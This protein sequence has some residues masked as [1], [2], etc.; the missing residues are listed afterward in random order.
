VDAKLAR[1][2]AQDRIANALTVDV[3]D[4]FSVSAFDDIVSRD[5]WGSY[6]SRVCRNTERLLQCFEDAGVRGTFFVLGWVAERFPQ[7]VR[8]IAAAGHEIGS[9]SFSH[10][11][12]YD[13]TPQAFREDV[14]RASAAISAAAG[15]QVLGYRAPSFSITERSLW[16]LDILIEEGYV[17]D[18]SIF[19]V[20]HDRYGIPDA[21]REFHQITRGGRTLWECPS[22]TVRIGGVNLPTGGGGY[23]R[24]LPYA[25]TRWS[26][27]RIN[28]V[29]RRPAVFYLHPWEI[30]PDQPRLGASGLS[31]IR[32]YA[33]L[34]KTEGRLKTLLSEFAWAPLAEVLTLEPLGVRRAEWSMGSAPTELHP[35]L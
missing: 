5:A 29:E 20:R 9:H 24:M 3:E 35:L 23:F 28:R 31:R 6:E 10:R 1:S 13:L 8:Q 32:H 22:S 4:Y 19:P 15:V 34:H 21:P 14:R 11:L 7:L 18:A 27:S 25:W 33:N 26:I 12:V 30:D 2:S 16:A 17:Y